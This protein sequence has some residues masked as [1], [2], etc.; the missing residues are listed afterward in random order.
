M[1]SPFWQHIKDLSARL[2]GRSLITVGVVWV[3]LMVLGLS[4]AF[5]VIKLPAARLSVTA[6]LPSTEPSLTV[7]DTPEASEVLQSTPQ[8]GATATTGSTVLPTI[9]ATAVTGSAYPSLPPL[10]WGDFGYGIA[11]HGLTMPDYTMRQIKEHLGFGWVK[12]Q[13]RWDHFSLEPGQMDWSGYDLMV[14]FAEQHGLKVLMSVVG[15]PAWS[16]SYTDDTPQAAP[17]DDLTLFVNFMGELV[18]RYSGK[19]H[20]V[21]IW[22]EQNLEREW[23]TAEGISA[24]RYVEMLRLTYQAVK[25]RDPNII[26]ISGALSPTGVNRPDP[27]N[28]SRIIVLDDFV[29]FQQMIDEG[30]LN[31]CDCVGAHHNGYNIP[32]DVAYDAG[33][34]D[35]SAI[36]RGPFDAPHHSWSFKSTLWGYHD[37]IQADGRDTPLCVTEFG[38]ASSEG[39][40][41]TPPEFE[42]AD[43]NTLEEQT[44]WI[45][46]AF[47]L[48]REW[49]FV[50]LAF[51]WNLDYSYKGGGNPLDSNAPYS[52]LDLTGAP[53]P[54]YEA[55]G[56]MSKIP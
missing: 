5:G 20:A 10:K 30:F 8:P 7:T 13:V 23:D 51:L 14:S 45:Q 35:S 42:F 44:Q 19:I 31:Y 24:S 41:G 25:S 18:D 43:D 26:V 21:E 32:P 22:N 54:A 55:L 17:P 46:E 53:R 48:M 11:A 38:W 2:T 50:R 28:A 34:N 3:L 49:G 16:R 39:F 1:E 52:I 40:G 29:Y 4:C 15:A 56:K 6:T 47:G 33:Y 37:M 36:F 12:Q 27:N 9:T